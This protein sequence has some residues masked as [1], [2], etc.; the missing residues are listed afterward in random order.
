MLSKLLPPQL[1]ITISPDSLGFANTA[2][3][4]KGD[5]AGADTAWIGQS[6]AHAAASLGLRMQQ[7]GYHMLVIGEPGSGRTSLVKDMVQ[8]ALATQAV[9]EDLVYLLNFQQAEK[10]LL[11]RLKAGKG[12]ELRILLDQFSRRQLRTTAAAVKCGK[13]CSW[14]ILAIWL[15]ICA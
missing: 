14:Q 12:N 2:E 13:A 1:H 5:A 11:L 10:P 3:L 6:R 7:P 8:Q 9:P 15:A 4:L